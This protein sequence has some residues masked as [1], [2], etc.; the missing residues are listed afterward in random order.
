V[1]QLSLEQIAEYWTQQA[2]THGKEPEASWSDR[3]VIH[4]EIREILKHL[5]D[6]DRVLDLGCANGYSTVQFA[7]QRNV[8]ILGVDYIPE[9]IEQA[10]QRLAALPALQG[11]VSFAVGDITSLD[12]PD[13]A[14]DKAVV[15]RV[16]IN[17]GE[18]ENQLR[19]LRESV[20]VL[21]PGGTL[22]LSEATLQGWRN[23]NALRREWHLPDIP[24][25]SFN[26][27]IDEAKLSADAAGLFETIEVV[28]FS[29]TY[30]V[31]TRVLKPLLAQA[32]GADID[33]ADPKMHWNHWFSQLP[34]SGDY[35]TQ[36]LFVLKKKQGRGQRR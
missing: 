19:G 33:V 10:K 18:W 30:F 4:M 8:E 21:R 6:G 31:G 12:L 17:L 9:M 3:P 26:N 14:Y 1:A 25:P 24:M 32:L 7:A 27:Y 28:N 20:R 5:D 23:L 15:V 29:S 22:L 36:K 13:N 16:I 35:G 2:V 11:N 34:A